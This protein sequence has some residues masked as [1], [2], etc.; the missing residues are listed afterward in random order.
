MGY[1]GARISG[2]PIESF[3][4]PEDRLAWKYCARQSDILTK[5]A[6]YEALPDDGELKFFSFGVHSRDYERDAKWD[7][8]SEFAE[9]Y[10]NRPEEFYY[11]SVGDIFDYEDAIRGL[12][13]TDTEIV[14]DSEKTLYLKI[15]G[16]PITIAPRSTYKISV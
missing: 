6:E 15:D 12:M 7:D 9:K 4:L 3:S 11:A 1:Y 5:M 14:N 13:V 2:A 10:G 16:E 8:L